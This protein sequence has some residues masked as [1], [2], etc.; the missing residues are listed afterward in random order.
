MA[1][2]KLNIGEIQIMYR[3]NKTQTGG[4]VCVFIAILSSRVKKKNWSASEMLAVLAGRKKQGLGTLLMT[5]QDQISVSCQK[6]RTLG[7]CKSSRGQS[8]DKL[9]NLIV[10]A[11]NQ[12]EA[13]CQDFCLCRRFPGSY[14]CTFHPPFAMDSQCCFPSHIIF[15]ELID[16]W[17][18]DNNVSFY[19]WTMKYFT[20]ECN[21]ST[22]GR[23]RKDTNLLLP[24][25]PWEWPAVLPAGGHPCLPFWVIKALHAFVIC[26]CVGCSFQ[27]CSG[28][29]NLNKRIGKVWNHSSCSLQTGPMVAMGQTAPCREWGAARCTYRTVWSLLLSN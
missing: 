16:R 14:L 25:A 19:Y 24:Y 26:F 18:Q 9:L 8:H 27:S 4:C 17:R 11:Y 12:M 29:I 7:F 6:Y 13:E 10:H 2:T 21:H 3:G 23:R 28:N 1:P 15:R 5:F 22:K 20:L